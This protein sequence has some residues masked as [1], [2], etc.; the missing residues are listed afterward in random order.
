MAEQIGD[1]AELLAKVVPDYVCLGKRTLQDNGS[2]LDGAHARQRRAGDRPD[3]GHHPRPVSGAP[4]GTEHPVD[5]IVYA[6]GFHANRYLWPM[7][8]TGR[9]GA[10]LAEQWGDRPDR[11]PRHHRAQL[12]QPL[13]PLR[14]RHQPG[15]RRQPHLPLRVPGAV[16][17]GLPRRAGRPH[18]RVDRVPARGPRRVQ[19]APPGRARHDGVVAPV[20]PLAAGTATPRGASTSSRRG[21]SS[22]TGTG[23][24]SPTSTTSSSPSTDGRRVAR[25]GHVVL[26]LREDDQR[27][28]PDDQQDA[29]PAEQD[30]GGTGRREHRPGLLLALDLGCG[31]RGRRAG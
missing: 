1:D 28:S 9:D 3:R 23:P 8:I 11:A 21:A 2:W 19:R 22:T 24:A 4:S 17:D 26:A 13:L 18:R 25:S 30:G 20:D 31:H 16:R 6:T 12:P 14:A 27:R 5:V 7:E 15:A 10:V 29:Q